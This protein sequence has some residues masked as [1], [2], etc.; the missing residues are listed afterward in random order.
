MLAVSSDLADNARR[1]GRPRRP[2]GAGARPAAAAGDPHAAT[3]CARSSG[4]TTA[5]RCWSPSAGC[6]RRRATTSC[7]TPSPAGSATDG[8]SRR[9]W[10]RSPATGPLQDE[11]AERIRAER[12]PVLLL[13]RRAD[14]ADLLGAADACVLPSRWEGSPF[15]A[16]EALR[17]G[18]PLVATRAGGIP[19]LVGAGAELVPVGDAAALADAVVRRAR[20]PGA[21]RGGW[22]RPVAGRPRAGPTRRP[23][24]DGWSPSTAS[25]SAP[26]GTAV[27]MSRWGRAAAVLLVLLTA[28]LGLPSPAGAAPRR[29]GGRPRAD[30][31]RPGP[32]LGRRR[33]RRRPRSCGRWPRTPPIGA[34]SVRAARSTTCILDGWATLGAGNRARVPGPDD[35]LPPVPVPTVPLPED[36]AAPADTGRHRP[37]RPVDA[38]CRTAACRSA[39]PASR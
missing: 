22:P 26:P 32:D 4:S 19:E 38:R 29:R 5:G 20:R 6:T 27:V 10:S 8:C 18:T 36:Q 15:T 17:A 31:R 16:Q 37:S 23:P 9:R 28:L 14:V 1:L 11:L 24:A 12:L 33:P 3:R 7:S 34:M 35:G 13:G 2:G 21:R 25:C 30:R 39:R